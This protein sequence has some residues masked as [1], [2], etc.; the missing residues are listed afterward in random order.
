MTSTIEGRNRGAATDRV[1]IGQALEQLIARGMPF[2][3]TAY[4]GSTAGP[5][6]API[7]LH[8]R[9]QRG[10][11]YLLTAPGDLGMA[12]AYVS[13]RPRDQGRA[14]GRPLR[15]PRAP[16]E[17]PPAPGPRA[18]RGAAARAQ[19]RP[20]PLRPAGATA[21]GGAAAL[22]PGP[23]GLPA[24]ADPGRR[25]D[26][27]PLRRVQPLLRA[28][29]RA[30]D[31]LHVRVLP[32]RRTPPWRRPRPSSTTWSPASSTCGRACGCSTSAAAGAGWSGT[33]P[34]TTASRC[35]A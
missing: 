25:G 22:A 30:L 17:Q 10:L 2:R 35:S 18:R 14:P 1:T 33:P 32:A 26:P 24:L 15:R 6:D 8:L 19:H 3:F 34:G 5:A 31:D 27:P 29:A 16:A 23:R 21:A 7:H 20:E 12:R 4:D 28:G 11:S 13:R 9:N